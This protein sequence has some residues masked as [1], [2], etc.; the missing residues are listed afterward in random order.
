MDQIAASA[1]SDSNTLNLQKL[2]KNN[3]KK[4]GSIFGFNFY[5]S[6]FLTLYLDLP[7]INWG[8]GANVSALKI[9]LINLPL[10]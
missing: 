1:M 9:Q 8:K 5:L 2:K 3:K 6:F 7:V 4:S 10:Q